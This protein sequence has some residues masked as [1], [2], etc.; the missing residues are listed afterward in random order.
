MSERTETATQSGIG[1]AESCRYCSSDDDSSVASSIAADQCS[2][3]ATPGSAG[4]STVLAPPCL[5]LRIV[6]LR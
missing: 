1:Q 4:R 5:A 3:G 2:G 6:L